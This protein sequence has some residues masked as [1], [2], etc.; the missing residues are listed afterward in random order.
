MKDLE[1][2]TVGWG[3]SEF[4]QIGTQN[5]LPSTEEVKEDEKGGLV[6]VCELYSPLQKVK[7]KH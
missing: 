7:Q 4:F 6:S 2:P 1:C 5:F 3:S